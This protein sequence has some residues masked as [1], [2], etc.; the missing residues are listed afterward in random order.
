MSGALDIRLPQASPANAARLVLCALFA[1]AL[2]PLFHAID[3]EDD[4]VHTPGGGI[5]YRPAPSDGELEIDRDALELERAVF[6]D[7]AVGQDQRP[8]AHPHPHD[9]HHAEHRDAA[10]DEWSG[11]S[12][13]RAEHEHPPAAPDRP[14]PLEHGADSFAHF[15][16]SVVVAPTT[17]D[18][19]PVFEVCVP[20]S[21]VELTPQLRPPSPSLHTASPR[22]PPLG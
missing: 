9:D 18:I 13:H 7:H 11:G 21:R 5:V 8:H 16:A 22:G 6:G 1:F 14:S 17:I 2:A 10:G 15:G 4:H 20:A 3:H 12:D 19:R